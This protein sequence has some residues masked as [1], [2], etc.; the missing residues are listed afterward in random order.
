MYDD[1][2]S[3]GYSSNMYAVYNQPEDG[4]QHTGG[5]GID[6][7]SAIHTIRNRTS[8]KHGVPFSVKNKEETVWL[9]NR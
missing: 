3:G 5:T 8:W 7:C 2:H 6:Y 4:W 1:Y 9:K